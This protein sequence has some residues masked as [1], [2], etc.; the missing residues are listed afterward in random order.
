MIYFSIAPKISFMKNKQNLKEG[1]SYL[2]LL[3][4]EGDSMFTTAFLGRL[5]GVESLDSDI[6]D[7]DRD[8]FDILDPNVVIHK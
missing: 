4:L 8:I 1:I 2:N 5:V 7:D 3:G 6:L